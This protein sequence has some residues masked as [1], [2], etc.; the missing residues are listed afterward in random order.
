MGWSTI[1]F[2]LVAFFGD[3]ALSLNFASFSLIHVDAWGCSS[4]MST[5]CRASRC[6][7]IS[8]SDDVSAADGDLVVFS[9]SLKNETAISILSTSPSAC[10]RSSLG[11]IHR[12]E[13]TRS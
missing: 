1:G 11:H 5:G 13:I 2:I 4:F 3:L 6:M 8:Q 7:N 10:A 12:D 9:A